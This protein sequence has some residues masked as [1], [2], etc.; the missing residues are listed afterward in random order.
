MRIQVL[1][2]EQ[3]TGRTFLLEGGYQVFVEHGMQL[4][5]S[6]HVFMT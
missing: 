5:I 4:D 1:A 3:S 6:F 2:I